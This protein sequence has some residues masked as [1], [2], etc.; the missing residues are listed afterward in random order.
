MMWGGLRSIGV[1]FSGPSR[2]VLAV[3]LGFFTIHNPAG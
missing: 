1:G 2:H 3:D